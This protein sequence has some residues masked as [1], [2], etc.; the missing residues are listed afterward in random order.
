MTVDVGFAQQPFIKEMLAKV[1]E[2]AEFRAQEGLSYDI[3]IDGSCNEKT[4]G[5]LREAGADVFIL[6]SS[7]LF[8]LASD[9]VEAWR[10]MAEGFHRVTGEVVHQHA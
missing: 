2:A 3:Q 4:F 10:L 8:N 7:G 6:G 9:T 5:P 1:A